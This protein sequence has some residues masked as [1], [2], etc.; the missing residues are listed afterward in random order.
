MSQDLLDI[1]LLGSEWNSLAGGV[2]TLNREL[3]IYLS[4]EPNVRVSLLVPEGACTMQDKKVAQNFGI[5]VLDASPCPGYSEPLEWLGF[6]PQDHRIDVVVGHSV[7]LG[8]Q[9]QVIKRSPEFQRCKW[10]QMVH[11]APEDLGKYKGYDNPTSRG[12]QK[13]WDEVGLCKSADLVVPV[14]PRLK[15]AY[16]SY[17]QGCKMVKDI[18]EIVPGLFKREFGDLVQK[19]KGESGDHFNV[20]LCGRGD[21]EDFDLKGYEIAVKAFADE[22]LKGKCYYLLFVG[23]PEGKQ[24]EVRKRLLNCGITDQ[25]LTVR[26]FVQSREGMKDL[27]CEVDLVIMPSK[28]EGFGLVA[29]EALSA[30][31]PVLVGKNTGFA[32]AVRSIPLGAYSI[33]DSE[34]PGKWAEAIEGVCVRHGVCL[35]ES[36][37]LRE[38]YGQVYCWKKQCEALVDKL[39]R[40]VY[41]DRRGTCTSRAQNRKLPQAQMQ[42]LSQE[43]TSGQRVMTDKKKKKKRAKE[44]SSDTPAKQG[45]FKENE[46]LGGGGMYTT[47]AQKRPLQQVQMQPLGSTCSNSGQTVMTDKKKK[48]KRAKENSSDTP[49][50]QGRNNRTVPAQNVCTSQTSTSSLSGIKRTKHGETPLHVAAMKGCV[51]SVRKL[52]TEGADPNTK[53]YEGW[54]PLH[55]ACNHGYLFIVELLLDHGAMIDTPG[56]SDHDT[57]LHDA[58]TN[59]RLEVAKLLV[60]RGAPRD[61]R[62]KQG[63]IPMD[64]ARTEEMRTVLS[65]SSFK[66]DDSQGWAQ[67][68]IGKFSLDSPKVLLGTGLSPE[69]KAN[70]QTCAVTLNAEIVNEFSLLVTHIIT[71]ANAKG[72]CQRTIKYLNGVLTGKWIVSYDWVVNCLRRKTWVD[73]SPY[74]VKGTDD[75]A[76]DA[77]KKAR[78][79]AVKQRPSLFDGCE[80]FFYGDFHRPHP[81]KEDLIQMIKY[82][83]G[84]ILSREPKPRVDETLCLPTSSKANKVPSQAVPVAP[85]VYHANPESKLYRCTQYIIYDSTTKKKPRIW[86]TESLRTLPLTWLM[87]CVSNFSILDSE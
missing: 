26:K 72:I 80:F 24:D 6:P 45:T 65:T 23:A 40:M 74:E 47:R 4:Q 18:F 32:G 1:T 7:K 59:G 56:G 64:Y 27:F 2:S 83:G 62:N 53:D 71:A 87:N 58:V 76:V 29:L 31:L 13:H 25:Q 73:E 11:T 60:R 84:K 61:I 79:N 57:P 86:D 55:E 78:I 69:Q 43:S 82:G 67:G 81:A 12:E 70:L 8:R 34:D 85:V 46:D 22:R 38:A 15:K 19:A 63:L 37:L 17:L 35:E 49:A 9:V 16:C 54:T 50:K 75:A 44:N 51:E 21:D 33:V 10:V 77:P 28:S 20:L 39:W 5:N 52:L 14:G 48:N 68:L 30:G 66:V 3:A 42:L 36:K 41:E